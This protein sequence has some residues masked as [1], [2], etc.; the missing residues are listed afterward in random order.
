MNSSTIKTEARMSPQTIPNTNR[1]RVVSKDG[2]VLFRQYCFMPQ[3]SWDS[4]QRLCHASNQSGSQVIQ[5]LIAIADLG[6]Q[7]DKTNE[8]R[9]T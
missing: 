3:A 9:N 1:Q 7:K 6:T 5:Q 4:L 2:T 8:P